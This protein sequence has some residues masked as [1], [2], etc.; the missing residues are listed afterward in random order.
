MYVTLE[1][2]DHH[3][4]TPPCTAA[5]LDAGIARV[6]V[7]VGDPDA[8]V[9]GRG[10][11]QLRDAGVEVSLGDG[12]AEGAAHYEAYAHHRRTG[13]PFVTAKFAA[14]LDG[15]IASTSGDSRWIS[16]P[17]TL[18]WAHQNRPLFDAMLVG[19]ETIVVDN[20]QLT[21]RPEGWSGAVPQPLRVVLD[22]RGRTPL[23]SRVLEDVSSSP[24]LIATTSASAA[25]ADWREAMA[26]RNVEVAALPADES[27]RVS[28]PELLD[29][30]G[31]EHGVV[32]L[33]V[34][35]GGEVLGS[36]FDQRLIDKVTAVVAPMIIGGDAQTAVRGRGAERM[37]DVLRLTNMTVERLGADMLVTGYP[38][39]PERELDIRIRPAGQ[40]DV[41][42]VD[43]LLASQILER[44]PKCEELLTEARAGDAVIW[45]A[46]SHGSRA[47]AQGNTQPFEDV[48]GVA[49]VTF[50]TDRAS[51]PC[52]AVRPDAP[53]SVAERLRDSC[54]A[55]ASGRDADW[56]TLTTSSTIGLNEEQYK[57][58]GYRYYRRD[59]NG[60]DV[61]IKRLHS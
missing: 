36:F 50:S 54:E 52:L 42:A 1:P 10:L 38:G 24:T 4:R 58:A 28:L 25:S 49:A 17:Q 56:L 9:S 41:D 20:P 47:D 11:E 30:L 35:G 60:S 16:G 55:S 14:S 61:L 2:C 12:A 23:G 29:L 37:R 21:A 27:G 32:S 6:V 48:L 44:P 40:A 22:S 46:T 13:R 45:L 57:S 34:E 33:L 31:R 26:S 53:A 43:Q 19:V 51:I 59:A 7:A 18:R 15:R 3:G 8:R 5:I 39:N